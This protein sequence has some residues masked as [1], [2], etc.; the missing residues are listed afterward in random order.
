MNIGNKNYLCTLDYAMELIKGK[1]KAVI[2]CHLNDS[3]CRF[4]ELQRKLPGVSHKIL[5]E[6][7]NELV[8]DQLIIKTVHSHTPPN[9]EYKLSEHGL[10]LFKIIDLLQTWADKYIENRFN[11]SS[12]L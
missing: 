1:W 2:I 8:D 9:V 4:L 5:S 11:S 7:L 6:K 3:S 10:E 12:D